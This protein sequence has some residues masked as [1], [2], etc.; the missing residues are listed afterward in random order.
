VIIRERLTAVKGGGIA[1]GTTPD[2]TAPLPAKAIIEMLVS[3][4]STRS[5][6]GSV[7]SSSSSTGNYTIDDV[8]QSGEGCLRTR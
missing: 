4:A 3:S 6:N 8:D 5:V 1:P 2:P 7:I